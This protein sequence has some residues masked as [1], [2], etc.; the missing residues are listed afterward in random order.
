MSNAIQDALSL[1][2]SQGSAK[3]KKPPNA[4]DNPNF[5]KYVTCD[6]RESEPRKLFIPDFG[7][8]T[9]T[10]IEAVNIKSQD[11]WTLPEAEY[12]RAMAEKQAILDDRKLDIKRA[13][14]L[15][16]MEALG[17]AAFSSGA[18][19][20]ASPFANINVGG[21]VIASVDDQGVIISQRELPADL[22]SQLDKPI[23]GLKG[24]LLAARRAEVL[25]H[26]F[27]GE[28]ERAPTGLTQ[29][30]FSDLRSQIHNALKPS[31]EPDMTTDPAYTE[32][33]YIKAM[34]AEYLG[35]QST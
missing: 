3:V 19:A 13:R 26:Y 20:S 2:G 29:E 15:A 25:A 8:T 1:M 28:V 9:G 27:S 14:K 10:Q 30:A 18:G 34:R 31:A 11:V 22:Q 16:A 23:P 32:I 4:D 12:K 35:G 7:W 33:E 5:G 21:V 17:A 6:F 24:L